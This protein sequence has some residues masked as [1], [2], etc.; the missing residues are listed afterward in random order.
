[1]N[2]IVVVGIALAIVG[3]GSLQLWAI[4]YDRRRFAARGARRHPVRA[5][6]LW[7]SVA[8]LLVVA[9]IVFYAM[10]RAAP[11]GRSGVSRLDSPVLTSVAEL[12]GFRVADE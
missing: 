3:G 8:G 5:R 12:H 10:G 1:M 9:A 4:R 7:I 6:V 2:W 11:H